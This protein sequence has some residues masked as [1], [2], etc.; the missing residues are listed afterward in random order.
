MEQVV[1]DCVPDAMTLTDFLAEHSI[2][3]IEKEIAV[4][5]RLK[6]FKFKIRALSS[7]EFNDSQKLAMRFDAKGKPQFNSMLFHIQII[8]RGCVYPNF[9]LETF[10][11]ACG[12]STPEQV[13]V[14]KLLPGEIVEIAKQIITLSGFDDDINDDIEEVKNY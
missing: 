1:T 9:K 14:K 3:G 5:E 2:E 11:K 8:I 4:S 7:A 13:I 12:C 6:N 10:V